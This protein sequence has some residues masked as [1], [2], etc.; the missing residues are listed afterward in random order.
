MS[1]VWFG[2]VTV[3]LIGC[4]ASA[5]TPLASRLRNAGI[6]SR[7]SLRARAGNPSIVI[8]TTIGPWLAAVPSFCAYITLQDRSS[9]VRIAVEEMNLFRIVM[10]ADTPFKGC[11]AV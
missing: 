8:S 6:G 4:I 11:V 3:G 2:Q 1:A 10:Y 5:C 7:G 9:S